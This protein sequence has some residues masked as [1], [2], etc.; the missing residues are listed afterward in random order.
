MRGFLLF[1]LA[2]FSL[3]LFGIPVFLRQV[4]YAGKE[5]LGLFLYEVAYALDLLGGT[6][7]YKTR[8]KTISAATGRKSYY[9]K[10]DFWIK[11]F[12]KWINWLFQDHSHCL[13]AFKAEFPEEYK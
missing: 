9:N 10:D 4:V 5:E 6:L 2:M 13:N 7:L 1:L 8:A 11:N 12:E 3:I